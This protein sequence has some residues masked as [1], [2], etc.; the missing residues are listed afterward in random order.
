MRNTIY[1]IFG[2][3]INLLEG[4]IYDLV[5]YDLKRCDKSEEVYLLFKDELAG[6]YVISKKFDANVTYWNISVLALLLNN[7]P[8]RKFFC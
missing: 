5:L 3:M 2:I 1:K 4:D 7:L 6:G 8:K